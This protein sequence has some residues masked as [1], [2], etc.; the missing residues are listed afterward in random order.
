MP[1]A[2]R[3]AR[4]PNK[5]FA[6]RTLSGS[7]A[8]QSRTPSAKAHL[9]RAG[10]RQGR[11]A[12]TAGRQPFLRPACLKR[13]WGP[14]HWRRGSPL[15]PTQKAPRPRNLPAWGPR[16]PER[17]PPPPRPAGRGRVPAFCQPGAPDTDAL[18]GV[19]LGCVTGR[20]KQRAGSLQSW[21]TGRLYPPSPF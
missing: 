4:V 21:Y 18:N 8:E 20:S 13:Y 14:C 16:T 9:G 19:L 3:E 7:K 1:A 15:E 12:R 10:Q 11:Q 5:H 2:R 6:S 17:Y